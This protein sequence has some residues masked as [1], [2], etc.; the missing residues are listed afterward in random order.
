MVQTEGSPVAESLKI[1]HPLA[2]KVAEVQLE[3]AKSQTAVSESKTGVTLVKAFPFAEYAL[4][5]V[6]EISLVALYAVVDLLMVAELVYKAKLK[7]SPDE[8]VKSCIAVKISTL[9]LLQI[10]DVIAIS[11]LLIIEAVTRLVFLLYHPCNRL[12]FV[13]QFALLQ[14]FVVLVYTFARIMSTYLLDLLKN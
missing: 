11:F 9:K 1:R 5:E 10:A 8:A 3:L 13:F 12:F 7:V 6:L 14:T 2:V 4:P